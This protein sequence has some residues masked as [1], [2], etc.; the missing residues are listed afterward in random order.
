MK[1]VQTH[2]APYLKSG[3]QPGPSARLCGLL[4]V[5]LG[6][7]ERQG[8]SGGVCLGGSQHSSTGPG[9]Q[10]SVGW[11]DSG[12]RSLQSLLSVG[13][14]TFLSVR[15]APTP[16]A[17]S[18]LPPNG[19]VCPPLGLF[20]GRG[21]VQH[22]WGSPQLSRSWCPWLNDGP[23]TP[24]S[25]AEGTRG[26]E[27]PCIPCSASPHSH[28]R[29]ERSARSSC[30]FYGRRNQATEKG[31]PGRGAGR[32][33]GAGDFPRSSERRTE[34]PD[35]QCRAWHSVSGLGFTQRPALLSTGCAAHLSSEQAD[36]VPALWHDLPTG[37]LARRT[38]RK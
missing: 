37:K 26:A 29:P 8:L 11:A 23:S 35:A 19:P 30:P 14:R 17:T 9:K 16:S 33:Q 27:G 18:Q 5:N 2:I 13:S 28:Q 34:E 15:P 24:A 25:A 31:S 1:S 4:C 3:L 6:S 10:G 20:W 36:K 7:P 32:G 12:T 38:P 22:P 21:S